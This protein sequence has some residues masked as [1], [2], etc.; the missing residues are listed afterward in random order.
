MFD[1]SYSKHMVFNTVLNISG[2][3]RRPV[4][5]SMLSQ[6]SFYQ[7]SAQYSFQAADY[8]PI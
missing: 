8:F 1:L 5:L 6:S 7:Y 4:H 2:T 3:S